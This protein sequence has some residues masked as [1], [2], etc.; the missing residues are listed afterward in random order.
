ME[1]KK[2][3][4]TNE[5]FVDKEFF[6]YGQTRNMPFVT[7]LTNKYTGQFIKTTK[8]TCLDIETIRE[9]DG[10]LKKYVDKIIAISLICYEGS[11]KL[12]HSEYISVKS[13]KLKSDGII[14]TDYNVNITFIP[15]SDKIANLLKPH[16][17]CV[18]LTENIQIGNSELNW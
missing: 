4:F 1:K 13:P 17:K 10:T 11:G 15:V 8:S 2:V 7:A 6:F 14:I 12:I 18:Q 9:F 5:K 16:T 3:P